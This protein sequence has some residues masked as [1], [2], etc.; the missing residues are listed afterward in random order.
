[1]LRNNQED[2]TMAFKWVLVFN[3]MEALDNGLLSTESHK[4]CKPNTE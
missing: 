4:C 2:M 3:G 1:M